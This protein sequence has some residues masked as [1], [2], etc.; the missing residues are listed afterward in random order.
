MAP[1]Q[2][3]AAGPF[4]A[5]AGGGDAPE[6]GAA[7]GAGPSS[8]DPAAAATLQQLLTAHPPN[9]HCGPPARRG[10]R[11]ARL[12][13]RRS[14]ATA[15][16]AAA[17]AAAS[18]AASGRADAGARG[19]NDTDSQ[20]SSGAEGS[21][22]SSE[23]P[24]AAAAG[25]AGAGAAPGSAGDGGGPW[26]GLFPRQL[27]AWRAAYSERVVAALRAHPPAHWARRGGASQRRGHA[28]G[29]GGAAGAPAA[30]GRP[31]TVLDPVT[32]QAVPARAAAAAASAAAAAA[33]AAAANGGA[34]EELF[35]PR[36]AELVA[37]IMQYIRNLWHLDRPNFA[38]ALQQAR[39]AAR[40]ARRR[41]LGA[42]ALKSA[43]VCCMTP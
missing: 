3:S 11:G 6:G 39:R 31:A 17:G 37:L 13:V 4:A 2:C 10:A 42:T 20:G 24:G 19:G 8:G 43:P 21:A 26:G 22:E 40:A 9:G 14:G 18:A 28:P 35:G 12:R 1:E 38:A 25:A 29:G 15:G 7:Y 27:D 5:F 16:A 33:A 34:D 30:N 41:L 23:A 36:E 32:G